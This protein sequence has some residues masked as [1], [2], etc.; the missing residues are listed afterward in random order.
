MTSKI[1]LGENDGN[2]KGVL[3]N[4]YEESLNGP[5]YPDEGWWDA[6]LADEPTNDEMDGTFEL[7]QDNKATFSPLK[8]HEPSFLNWQKI[9]GVFLNDEIITL[10]VIGYNRGGLLVS[11][12]DIHGFVPFSHLIDIPI[13]LDED[14]RE[15][16]LSE[17][18]NREIRLKVIECEQEKERI[19]FSERAALAKEGK[20]KDLLQNLNE[21]EIVSGVVTNVT[22]FGVF[23]DLGG[24]EGLI[25]VSELSWGRVQN[26]SDIL[27]VN[28]NVQA[29]VLHVSK[30]EGKIAL[31][32]KRL[33]ENPWEILSKRLKGGEKLDAVISSIVKYGAFARLKEGIEGLIHISSMNFPEGCRRIDDFL[34]EG[35]AVRVSVLNIDAKKRR[36]GLRLEYCLGE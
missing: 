9:M 28:D 19:V 11:N 2:K 21:G 20:R 10:D 29:Q 24:L 4:S 23:V 30:E 3:P 14:N 22:S 33:T 15:R 16:Y 7:N 12:E 1:K 27:R 8:I 31:S 34:Y 5:D 6:V 17:Y 25:H 18:L 35:Q 36:L 32:L 26:P 13:D